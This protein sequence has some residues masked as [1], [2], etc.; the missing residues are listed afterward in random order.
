[1]GG[2]LHFHGSSNDGRAAPRVVVSSSPDIVASLGRPGLLEERVADGHVVR[3]PACRSDV[4][5]QRLDGVPVPDIGGAPPEVAAWL[6]MTSETAASRDDVQ[7]LV[8]SIYPDLLGPAPWRHRESGWLTQQPD[9]SQAAWDA[10]AREWF[11]AQFEPAPALAPTAAADNLGEIAR[12]V[13]ARDCSVL[14]FTVSTYD[15]SDR[16]HRYRD[17]GD[18]FALRAHR[19][20]AQLEREATSLGMT[21]VDVD[22]AVAELG[23]VD[24]VVSPGI[25]TPAGADYVTEE[26]I[27]AVDQTGALGGSLQAPIMR[28]TVPAFDRRTTEGRLVTWHVAP[29]SQVNDG[30]LLFDVKFDAIAQKVGTARE[31][32]SAAQIRR[33]E[34]E[35]RKRS[36]QVIVVSAVAGSE[37]FIHEIVV[38]AGARVSAGDTAAVATTTLQTGP[39]AADEVEAKMRLGVRI[40]GS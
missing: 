25:L 37:A 23:A 12:R 18:T 4:L 10:P 5:L 36:G 1:M 34:E 20:L 17:V 3:E 16:V 14:V 15:P 7:L 29:G 35:R 2:E 33:R 21:I 9:E 38:E 6:E 31:S 8:L 11:E 22:R 27:S 26:A 13:T 32:K 24:H 28:V 40:A 39:I 30:D 19:T